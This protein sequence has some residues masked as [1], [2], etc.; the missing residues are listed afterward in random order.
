MTREIANLVLI[1]TARVYGGGRHE[2]DG[3]GANPVRFR[4]GEPLGAEGK[5]CVGNAALSA[6]IASKG[7]E[8]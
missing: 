2:R 5:A 3:I 7:W 6:E 8:V 1:W 4:N